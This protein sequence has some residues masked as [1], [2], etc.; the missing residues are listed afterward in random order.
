MTTPSDKLSGH[1]PVPGGRVYYRVAGYGDGTPLLTLHGGPGFAHNAFAPLAQLGDER[2]VIF[3]DQLGCGQS[4]RPI[5]SSLW[6][7]ER[8]V[9]EVD[10]VRRH[11]GLERIHLLGHSWGGALAIDYLLSDAQSES[12]LGAAGVEKLILVSPLV[13]TRRWLA[14]AASLK[15]RLPH[16]IRAVLDDCERRGDYT[17][18]GY[19]QACEVFYARHVCRIRPLPQPYQESV[20]GLGVE[21][22]THMWGPSEFTCTGTLRDYERFDRLG[23]IAAPTLWLCGRHDEARPETIAAYQRQLPGSQLHVFE[24]SAHMSYLEEMDEFLRVVRA[25]LA[26]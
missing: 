19:A 3:Y 17:A 5:D 8:A 16:D 23:E 9:Q 2:R 21:V 25:F 18:E 15:D 12:F 13:S 10:A 26:G 20:A 22:Y 1:A 11:L 6:T 24:N 14:D 7:V 4:D